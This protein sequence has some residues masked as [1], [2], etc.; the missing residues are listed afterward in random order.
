MLLALLTFSGW[1]SNKSGLSL[2][3]TVFR[4]D[5]VANPLG[6]PQEGKEQHLLTTEFYRQ[7]VKCGLGG[8]DQNGRAGI[9]SLTF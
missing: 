9:L 6:L 3:Q 2:G 8:S 1:G 5:H 4:F 7:E